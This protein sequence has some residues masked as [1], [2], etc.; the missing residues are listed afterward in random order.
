M[1]VMEPVAAMVG[2]EEG[3]AK[4]KADA[5]KAIKDECEAD[6]EEQRMC[7]SSSSSSTSRSTLR[8]PCS[9]F[10]SPVGWVQTSRAAIA[11]CNLLTGNT[12]ASQ[13]VLATAIPILND[14]LAALDTIK[15]AD[16]NYIKKLG[17]PPGAIKLVRACLHVRC[18]EPRQ[19]AVLLLC[20]PVHRMK[21]AENLC[22]HVTA[23]FPF[24]GGVLEA[25]CVILDVKPAKIKDDSGKM[26]A[27]YWKPSDFLQRLKTYDKDNIPPRIIAEIRSKYLTN[28]TFTPETAKKASP[29]AEGMC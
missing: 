3:R 28:E 9:V 11:A 10:A 23:S 21:L 29:A 1:G 13:I 27:D 19:L 26:V 12:D 25:V 18:P 20:R 2:E 5:A 7:T 22:T 16:I 6:L 17:N 8:S 24:L 4:G 15:E 14:A